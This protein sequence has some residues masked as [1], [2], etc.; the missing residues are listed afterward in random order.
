LLFR[1]KRS[2]AREKS[3]Y[4]KHGVC[5]RK[6]GTPVIEKSKN[7]KSKFT[8]GDLSSR[9]KRRRAL[10]LLM[11]ELERLRFAED[12]YMMRIPENLQGSD[13]HADAECTVDLLTDAITALGDAY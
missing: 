5:N 9:Q 10:K 11:N 3:I 7:T 13:A 4:G 12:A 6:G 8:L 2:A 1:G